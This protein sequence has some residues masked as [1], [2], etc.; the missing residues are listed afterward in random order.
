MSTAT[1]RLLR[2]AWPPA[3][4]L[5]VIVLAWDIVANAVHASLSLPGMW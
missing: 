2:S 4:A 3:L 1:R 5:V